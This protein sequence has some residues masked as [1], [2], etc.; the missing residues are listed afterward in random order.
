MSTASKLIITAGLL[1]VILFIYLPSQECQF[2]YDD[3]QTIV[4]N[5]KIQSTNIIEVLGENPFRVLVNLTFAAQYQLHK[6]NAIGLGFAKPFRILNLWLHF[7]NAI[8][9]FL[10]LRKIMPEKELAAISA[11]ALFLL[12]PL[13]TETVNL[14]ST[15]FTLMATLFYM[16]ALYFYLAADERPKLDIAFAACFVMGLLC[17]ETVA[18]LPLALILINRFRSKPQRRV[19]PALI[20]VA[21]YFGLRLMWQIE[22]SGPAQE[23]LSSAQ[24]F[25]VQNK[26][27]WLYL[28]KIFLPIHLNF[29][30]D[31]GRGLI[32]VLPFL[33]LNF[34]LLTLA[35][36]RHRNASALLGLLFVILLLPTSSVIPLGEV[37]KE[38]RVYMSTAVAMTALGLLIFQIPRAAALK[39]LAIGLIC[40]CFA[41]LTID[42]NSDWQSDLTLWRDTTSRSPMK[43]RP[44]YNL[45]IAYQLR[46][47]LEQAMFFFRW[48]ERID[49]EHDKVKQHIELVEEALKRPEEVEMIRK[50]LN[51]GQTLQ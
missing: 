27:V 36:I 6:K 21:I 19:I 23:P 3:L 47:E 10:L 44:A 7:T 37:I 46:I 2:I 4:Y 50:R 17:K 34:M 29:D 20:V 5:P 8:I 22:L 16:L 51:S 9:L 32:T 28:A 18:T 25:L 45:G 48:A 30:P 12:H 14:I 42:R 41:G 40:L 43:L 24:Y 13:A 33:A 1:L 38:H 39:P 11:A 31:I 49:P 35:L 15:R 26:V